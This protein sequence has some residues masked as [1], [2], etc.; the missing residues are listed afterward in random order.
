MYC[1]ELTILPY[2]HHHKQELFCFCF[3]FSYRCK[4]GHIIC[5]AIGLFV[6]KLSKENRSPCS[7]ETLSYEIGGCYLGSQ[8]FQPSGLKSKKTMTVCRRKQRREL[9]KSQ[10]MSLVLLGLSQPLTQSSSLGHR[11]LIIIPFEFS[12]PKLHGYYQNGTKTAEIAISFLEKVVLFTLSENI[13]D[14]YTSLTAACFS[15]L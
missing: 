4:D 11:N 10:T 14:Y 2:S 3:C 7:R 1:R 6:L 13:T 9:V 12:R 5:P 15:I 8:Y